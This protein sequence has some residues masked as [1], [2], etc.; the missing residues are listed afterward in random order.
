MTALGVLFFVS[1][2][3]P[4]SL[5]SSPCQREEE[6]IDCKD[7]S[8]SIPLAGFYHRKTLVII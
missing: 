4:H 3:D 1:R 7:F 6:K 2:P 5:A 8:L